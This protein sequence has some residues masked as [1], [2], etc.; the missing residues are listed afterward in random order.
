M[1]A[2]TLPNEQCKGRP[3]GDKLLFSIEDTHD[4]IVFK[5]SSVVLANA[6]CRGDIIA[7]FDLVVLGDIKA[8][9]VVAKGRLFCLG[10]IEAGKIM[11]N[12]IIATKISAHVIH[13]CERIMAQEIN[14]DEIRSDGNILVCKDITVE[15]LI[16]TSGAIVCG[17][18]LYASYGKVKANVIMA[19][20]NIE[21]DEN[22]FEFANEPLILRREVGMDEIDGEFDYNAYKNQR[23]KEVEMFVK[24]GDLSGLAVY[25]KDNKDLEFLS[26]YTM[27]LEII[28][29]NPIKNFENSSNVA[30]F[31]DLMQFLRLHKALSE[32]QSITQIENVFDMYC[33]CLDLLHNAVEANKFDQIAL[34]TIASYQEFIEAINT[35]QEYG[36]KIENSSQLLIAIIDKVY[37]TALGINAAYLN[38]KFSKKGWKINE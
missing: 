6:I 17:E 27:V 19:A 9:S 37:K 33:E 38:E 26:K 16:E 36:N 28:K 5:A 23:N 25:L 4:E 24:K 14:A 29:Q 31:I 12:E 32:W 2:Y 11:A 22:E 30:K 1:P 34:C 10:S 7:N 15:K 13:S 18:G 3:L 8:Y 21:V 20:D 35:I